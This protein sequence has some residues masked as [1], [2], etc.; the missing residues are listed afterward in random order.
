MD[1]AIK[2]RR[3]RELLRQKETD[4]SKNLREEAHYTEI[5]N[6]GL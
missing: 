2:L 3:Q 6:L 5:V 4:L 1:W